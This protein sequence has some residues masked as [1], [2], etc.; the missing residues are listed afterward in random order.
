M[1]HWI[2]EMRSQTFSLAEDCNYYNVDVSIGEAYM[3]HSIRQ[4]INYAVG[5]HVHFAYFWQ[6]KNHN[7]M[8]ERITG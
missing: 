6:C 4:C 2:A 8:Q 3:T 7:L 1:D 5:H